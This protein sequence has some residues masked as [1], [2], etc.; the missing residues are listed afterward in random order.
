[1]NDNKQLD[2]VFLD[3]LSDQCYNMRFSPADLKYLANE[4]AL[5]ALNKNKAPE[6][7]YVEKVDIQEAFEKALKEKQQKIKTP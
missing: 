4:A 5:K 7:D 6:N 1:M 3:D 2:K